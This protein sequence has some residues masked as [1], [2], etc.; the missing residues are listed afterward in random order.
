MARNGAQWRVAWTMVL[1]IGLLVLAPVASAAPPSEDAKA[2]CQ[3][4][5]YLYVTTADGQP[6]MNAGKCM[7]YIREGGEVIQLPRLTIDFTRPIDGQFYVNVSGTMLQPG[8]IVYVETDLG[9]RIDIYA[10]DSSGNLSF[11]G[12]FYPCETFAWFEYSTLDQDGVPIS[13][14]ETT[15][16]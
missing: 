2:K 5:G 3:G 8:A 9:S 11:T 7:K 6:F 4:D 14:R 1:V 12:G 15:P 16:C 13:A 10:V